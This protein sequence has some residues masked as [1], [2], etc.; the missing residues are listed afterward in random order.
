MRTNSA[1]RPL[2]DAERCAVIADMEDS[3]SFPWSSSRGMGGRPWALEPVL[4]LLPSN[5]RCA[6]LALRTTNERTGKPGALD[7]M[8]IYSLIAKPLEY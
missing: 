3:C 7:E 1:A 5:G 2:N 4:N 6:S 8:G